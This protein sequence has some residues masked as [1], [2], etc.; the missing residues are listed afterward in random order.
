MA[1]LRRVK[2][3]KYRWTDS[4]ESN[5]AIVLGLGLGQKLGLGVVL[6]LGLGLELDTVG[7][8]RVRVRIRVRFSVRVR[9]CRPFYMSG[10]CNVGLLP[11]Y[12]RLFCRTIGTLDHF[13]RT[14]ETSDY[15]DVGLFWSD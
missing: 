2:I 10:Y 14:K 13:R 6:G 3:P 12:I 8:L 9:H 5:V 11:H 15:R 1:I 7:L 4:Q